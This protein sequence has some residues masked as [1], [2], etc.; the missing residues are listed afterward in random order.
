VLCQSGKPRRRGGASSHRAAGPGFAL[1]SM[2]LVLRAAW[3]DVPVRPLRPAGIGQSNP[4][5]H[6]GVGDLVWARDLA[7]SATVARPVTWL[8]RHT[9]RPVVSI[10]IR[11][12]SEGPLRIAATVD[13]PFWV[14]GRGWVSATRL[15]CGD[16]L[17][18][19]LPGLKCVV[20]AVTAEPAPARVFNIEVAEVH[21]Y[22]VG[23]AGVLVHN[24]SQPGLIDPDFPL[25]PPGSPAFARLVDDVQHEFV[26]THAMLPLPHGALVALQKERLGPFG[27]TAGAA[28]VYAAGNA[29]L[30]PTEWASIPCPRFQRIRRHALPGR[31]AKPGHRAPGFGDFLQTRTAAT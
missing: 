21:N 15:Q 7:R 28:R 17:H 13:H 8:F 2:A 9:N 31:R 18:G 11:V 26:R 1:T 24:A 30:L 23:S 6:I 14:E 25:P 12:D 27:A 29:R 20:D 4:I 3:P 22:F 16:L 10:H 19:F 5:E